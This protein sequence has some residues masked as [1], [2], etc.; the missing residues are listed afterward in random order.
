[1]VEKEKLIDELEQLMM[2]LNMIYEND[3]LYDLEEEKELKS[4]IIALAKDDETKLKILNK[5]HDRGF[6]VMLIGSLESED[7]K[8]ELIDAL[9]SQYDKSNIIRQLHSDDKK[10]ELL[11]EI[12]EKRLIL[13]ILYSINDVEKR[14]H[15]LDKIKEHYDFEMIKL[16]TYKSIEDD[17]KKIEETKKLKN[18]E[19]RAQVLATL[20]SDDNKIKVLEDMKYSYDRTEIILSLVDQNKRIELIDTV[21]DYDYRFEI[22]KS[23]D[24]ISEDEKIE[25]LDKLKN[26]DMNISRD[27]LMF[28]LVSNL[29]DEDKK[30]QALAKFNIPYYK[31]Q[32]VKQISDD[33]KKV[34]LFE[35]AQ[36][37]EYKMGI[38][39]QI[40]N[41]DIKIQLIDEIRNSTHVSLAILNLSR[42]NIR[43]YVDVEKA[44]EIDLP[45]GMT[46]GIEIESQGENGKYI[47]I[48]DFMLRDWDIKG[49]ITLDDYDGVE[50]TSPIMTGSKEDSQDVYTICELL[51]RMGQ[52]VDEKCGGHVHIGANYLDSRQSYENLM[53]IW[54]NLEEEIYILCNK[55]GDVP[56]STR[57]CVPISQKIKEALDTG[58]IDISNET[59]LNQYIKQLKAIQDVRMSGINLKNANEGIKTIEFRVANGSLD[60]K[61]WI[62]NINLF[63]GIIAASKELADIQL[64]TEPLTD[65]ENQ[66][67]SDFD[68]IIESNNIQEKINA[69]LNLITE[70]EEKKS[71]YLNRYKVNHDILEKMPAKEKTLRER[72]TKDT[73]DVRSIKGAVQDIRQGEINDVMNDII[74][75]FEASQEPTCEEERE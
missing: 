46:I 14:I 58:S 27:D 11:D 69:F 6:R 75:V 26:N 66:K 73:I 35:Q 40:E 4:Q 65:D 51:S 56:R 29:T 23:L 61:T 36:E 17:D 45:D 3:E 5:V 55:E 30:I 53:N 52:T 7:K 39:S 19:Q 12:T 50:V 68:I 42:D 31:L 20:K 60:A 10:I 54:C 64:K 16:E 28:E 21:M 34:E 41:E 43:K 13:D 57:Y 72:M 48:N 8:I 74:Q 47:K 33:S 22:I 38:L 24:E 32:V 71:I 15:A 49:D 67:L 18:L 2:R 37:P 63:G 1:M 62:E 9:R 70:D 44:N 59:E 25:L